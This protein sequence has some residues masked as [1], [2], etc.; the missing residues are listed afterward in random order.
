MAHSHTTI[1]FEPL[2]VYSPQFSAAVV[3]IET[4]NP[5]LQNVRL[6]LNE[7]G[8][9]WIKSMQSEF[10]KLKLYGAEENSV[11]VNYWTNSV[12]Y[13]PIRPK[14]EITL[15]L[16]LQT[17]EYNNQ[18]YLTITLIKIASHGI[19][20]NQD[21]PDIESLLP[22]SHKKLNSPVH[23]IKREETS[24]PQAKRQLQKQF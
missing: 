17:K 24:K 4:R 19:Q 3:T 14:E 10:K 5:Y 2:T 6:K 11:Y 18:D 23:K 16:K 1:P 21:I 9:K 8:V 20:D 12:D 13:K 22:I 15:K 7:K